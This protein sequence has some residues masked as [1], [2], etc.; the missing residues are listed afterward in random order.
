MAAVN[1]LNV[2]IDEPYRNVV[3]LIDMLMFTNRCGTSVGVLL[4]FAAC[5]CKTLSIDRLLCV[6]QYT[7]VHNILMYF[8]TILLVSETSHCLKDDQQNFVT[9]RPNVALP[10]TR[11]K[12]TRCVGRY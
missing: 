4:H 6:R 8:K 1:D 7:T 5:D 9:S 3:R 11:L 2:F 12:M 10:N